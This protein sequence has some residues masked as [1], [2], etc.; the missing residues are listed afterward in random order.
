MIPP[1][2]SIAS[3]QV[4]LRAR[5]PE[6]PDWYARLNPE[7]LAGDGPHIFTPLELLEPLEVDELLLRYFDVEDPEF[8]AE[9]LPVLFSEQT[10]RRL[11]HALHRLMEGKRPGPIS[12]EARGGLP[13][14][15][16]GIQLRWDPD[17]QLLEMTLELDAHPSPDPPTR[18]R[19]WRSALERSPTPSA[20]LNH[21]GT[22]CWTNL[23]WEAWAKAPDKP[24]LFL[25]RGADYADVSLP[26]QAELCEAFLSALDDAP[27]TVEVTERGQ[28]ELALL[29]H[30]DQSW[31][32]ASF[33]P[34]HAEPP[35]ADDE[36]EPEAP[37]PPRHILLV[38]D[39][40]IVRSAVK[41][42]LER[43]GFR[44]TTAQDGIE[45]LEMI[46]AS[47]DAATIDIALLDVMMPRMSGEQAME[48]L[49]ARRPDL[50]I[51]VFSGYAEATILERLGALPE[52]AF[53]RK[54]F[55]N[56]ELL[57]HI[58]QLLEG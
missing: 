25:P 51:I 49:R 17:E 32:L 36:P 41:R 56:A 50:P 26:Q 3:T 46:E 23:A 52:V 37:A 39:D 58:E 18:L 8:F 57:K 16:F 30:Q 45:A 53:L 12:G 55:R 38:D 24:A 20:F 22:V 29:R 4:R 10:H 47:T 48:E 40:A 54:P 5:A 14:R 33:A 28:L 9:V 44:V 27:Q 42:G 31:V 6:L 34:A 2:D 13:E 21:E 19:F 43:E 1:G 35:P 7:Q 15:R 11:F